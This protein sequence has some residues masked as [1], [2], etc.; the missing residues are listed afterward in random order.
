MPSEKEI[1]AAAKTHYET[2][3]HP[4]NPYPARWDALNEYRKDKW[5]KHMQ[6]AP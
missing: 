5:R 6:A 4:D 1:E 2:G 3:Q